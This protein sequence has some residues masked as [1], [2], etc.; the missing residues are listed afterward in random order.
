MKCLQRTQFRVAICL[1]F[2]LLSLAPT[3]RTQNIPWIV[4][5]DSCV[6][7]IVS[8]GH[9]LYGISANNLVI[10]SSTDNGTLWHDYKHPL[11]YSDPGSELPGVSTETLTAL[12]LEGKHLYYTAAASTDDYGVPRTACGIRDVETGKGVFGSCGIVD[13]FLI[14]GDFMAC[15]VNSGD[16]RSAAQFTLDRGTH[17]EYIQ[18]ALPFRSMCKVGSKIYACRGWLISSIDSL[19]TA[20]VD[21]LFNDSSGVWVKNLQAYDSKMFCIATFKSKTTHVYF[22]VDT[23]KHWTA[24]DVPDSIMSR[25]ESYALVND[26]LVLSLSHNPKCITSDIELDIEQNKVQCIQ[27]GSILDIAL[28]LDVQG[29]CR[30]EV[31][32]GLGR[33]CSSAELCLAPHNHARLSVEN[34]VP[35]VYYLQIDCAG[36]HRWGK[37]V[38]N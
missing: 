10:V 11:L 17:W 24:L 14:S 34:L 18:G 22:S 4:M 19:Q 21:E 26:T 13:A 36:Q 33:L 35:G 9:T 38:K 23:A 16:V 1:S 7:G 32:D 31:L 12:G 20:P 6:H 28:D 3:L 2:A 29:T 15:H 37:F 27:Y 30:L 25:I 8:D 5:S